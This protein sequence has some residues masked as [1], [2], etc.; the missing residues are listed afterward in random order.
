MRVN[1]I[2]RQETTQL[3]PTF[4]SSKI[5]IFLAECF[6]HNIT[7]L[8]T[9]ICFQLDDLSVFNPSKNVLFIVGYT[10]QLFELKSPT[11][12]L[13]NTF[14]YHALVLWNDLP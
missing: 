14:A 4:F 5:H 9:A 2:F 6:S 10:Q 1:V 8:Q 12:H 11:I 7:F 13:L 3:L